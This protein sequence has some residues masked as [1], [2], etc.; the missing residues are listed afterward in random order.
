[1]YIHVLC[2]MRDTAISRAIRMHISV[3]S[4]PLNLERMLASSLLIL[5][6]SASLDLPEGRDEEIVTRVC[7]YTDKKR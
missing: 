4:S 2:G 6:L 3:T 1:M 7:T 5:F